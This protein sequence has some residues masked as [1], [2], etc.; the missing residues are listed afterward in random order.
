MTEAKWLA[1]DAAAS[2]LEFL[3]ERA[4]DRKRRLFACACCR[5]IWH[6]LP[7]ERTRKAIEVA[8]RFAAGA[9]SEAALDQAC[10]SAA[11]ACTAAHDAGHR[12][13]GPVWLAS[14][15]VVHATWEPGRE[16]LAKNVAHFARAASS[17]DEPAQADLLREV[18][19]PFHALTLN[20]TCLT[21]LANSLAQAAYD[22]RALPSGWLDNARLEVLADALEEAGCTDAEL[23]GHLRSPG[24][25]VRG[26]W[27]LDLVLGKG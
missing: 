14:F 15:A 19:N 9:A 25:H 11:A 5:R 7:D 24:P 21:P 13:D 1:C 18:F 4:S 16:Y 3:Q 2:M 6:L 10:R 26:C 17:V 27:A 20:P 23:L 12:R 8:E 22:D